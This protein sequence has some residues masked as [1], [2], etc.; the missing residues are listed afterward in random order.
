MGEAVFIRLLDS[1]EKDASLRTAVDAIRAGNSWK[2]IFSVVP[3]SFSQ[4]PGSPFA[5][6]VSTELRRAYVDLSPFEVKGRIVRV[7][8]QPGEGFRFLRLAWEVP[9]RKANLD[10]RFYQKGGTYSPYYS[11]IHL[12]VDWDQSRQTYRGFYGRPGRPNERPSNY[13]FFF[14]PGLTWPRRTTSGISVRVLP[15]GCIFADKGPVAFTDIEDIW[16]LL[17]LMNSSAFQGFVA[18]QLGAADVAA[19]SY[20]VGIIQRTPVPDLSG[21]MCQ[22]LSVLA[23]VCFDHKRFRDTAI[24]TSRVFLLPAVLQVSSETLPSRIA[25]WQQHVADTEQQ[26]AGNQREID[27][28]AFR[29]YGIEGADRE[30]IKVSLSGTDEST[31]GRDDQVDEDEEEATTVAP[32]DPRALVVDLISYAVGCALGRWDVRLAT[33]ERATPELPDPFAPLPV[34]SP[35][36]LQDEVGLPLHGAPPGYPLVIDHDGILVDDLEHPDDVIRRVGEVLELVWT[37][38]APSGGLFSLTGAQAFEQEAC[39]CL[40]IRDLRDYFRKPGNGGFWM[41]HV[42]RYSKSRRKAPI[43]WLLQSPRRSYSLWLYYHQLDADLLY[44][45]LV[46]YVEPKV[47][48]E[49][50]RLEDLNAQ[51]RA[52]GTAGKEARQAEKAIERQEALLNDVEEFRDRL[53]RAADLN[54]VPDLND[55]VV[56]NIAP[57]WELVPWSEAKSYWNDLLAGK[58][59]WSSIG[60]QL[61]EKG[62]VK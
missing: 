40:G 12:V 3:A 39:S 59:E 24:E 43:Y 20:E 29:L 61:R 17:G 16:C 47:N 42:N 7:G 36:M 58:Y 30:A 60:K 23:R 19:R 18:V 41:D 6:W 32:T 5:Y 50:T 2:E 48:R 26:L 1:N 57:L 9:L 35:G 8:G 51:R 21:P 11:D 54:L 33:G 45:A 38:Q 25:V 52:F 15:R 10:W 53:R 37:G 31:T 22:T 62:I 27:D 49:R 13:Q 28:I 46:N 4:V 44:K 14:Q 55:G 34:C 56:L